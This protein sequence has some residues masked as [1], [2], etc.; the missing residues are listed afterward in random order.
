MPVKIIKNPF[1]AG[2]QL[3]G[4]IKL[5]ILLIFL[6][7]FEAKPMFSQEKPVKVPKGKTVMING[8]CEPDEWSDAAKIKATG[9]YQLF[10]KKNSTFVFICIASATPKNLMV[11]LYLAGEN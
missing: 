5:S 10:F 3:R 1:A 2:F 11:D 6:F 9:D 4:L 7:N 8:V